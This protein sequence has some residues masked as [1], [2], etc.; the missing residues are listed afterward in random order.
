MITCL[1]QCAYLLSD[2]VRISQYFCGVWSEVTHHCF[3][4]FGIYHSGDLDLLTAVVMSTQT[5][6]L[7]AVAPVLTIVIYP[8]HP[9]VV[10]TVSQ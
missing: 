5:L 7:L 2:T 6:N 3:V 1:D 8:I 9:I 10:I 4:V